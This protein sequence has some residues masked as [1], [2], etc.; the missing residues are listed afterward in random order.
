MRR[1]FLPGSVRTTQGVRET[2]HRGGVCVNEGK[3]CG[4]VRVG[5]CGLRHAFAGEP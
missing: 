3:F 1:G 4:T 2:E 5:V